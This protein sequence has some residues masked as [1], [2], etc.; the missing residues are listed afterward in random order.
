M[1]MAAIKKGSCGLP[2]T[3]LHG[4]FA[5]PSHSAGDFELSI[6]SNRPNEQ[7]L[8]QYS[9]F[10]GFDMEQAVQN[11]DALARNPALATFGKLCCERAR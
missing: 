3:I 8:R 5:N 1:P 11:A 2:M 6:I 10:H 7:Q 9:A 4:V